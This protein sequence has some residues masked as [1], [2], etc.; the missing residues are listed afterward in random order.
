MRNL[1]VNL[2]SSGGVFAAD[3]EHAD[4]RGGPD[5]GAATETGHHGNETRLRGGPSGTEWCCQLTFD[6]YHQHDRRRSDQIV[7]VR[8]EEAWNET[9][10]ADQRSDGGSGRK[11][12]SRPST[13][14]FRW[15]R[16]TA[17]RSGS[18]HCYAAI[19]GRS[20]CRRNPRQSGDGP[21]RV[22]RLK[23][24]AE[25]PL[26]ERRR[27]PHVVSKARVAAGRCRP[28]RPT[29]SP[30]QLKQHW[31]GWDGS[32][33]GARGVRRRRRPLLDRRNR[34]DPFVV[35]TWNICGPIGRVES[36]GN[37]VLP[38]TGS[39]LWRL[40]P[41]LALRTGAVQAGGARLREY[42]AVGSGNP[43]G[44]ESSGSAAIAGPR[45]WPKGSQQRR[46]EYAEE[47]S[48]GNQ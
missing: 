7:E 17:Q 11:S 39:A 24:T 3:E 41:G 2:S 18:S 20:H 38:P 32:A 46:C 23:S 25:H 15:S 13:S 16:D 48:G 14:W 19:T 27:Q 40:V 44:S 8:T 28:A 43:E 42:S 22:A 37:A 26:C 9:R 47:R 1:C 29:R 34:H 12:S 45:S 33:L 5:S 10:P 30:R 31:L 35:G 36:T 4:A 21:V 6:H